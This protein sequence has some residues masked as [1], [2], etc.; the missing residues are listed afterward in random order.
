MPMNFAQSN[1][2][3]MALKEKNMKPTNRR[4]IG[5]VATLAFM[6]V[7]IIFTLGFS[8]LLAKSPTPMRL[9]FFIIAGIVW[10]FPLYPLFKWMRPKPGEIA[11]K[12]EPPKVSR[13]R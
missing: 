8:N 1:Q 12:E 11:P 5:L 7:Y 10:V 6:I 4:A 13:L 3:I 2:A 9:L